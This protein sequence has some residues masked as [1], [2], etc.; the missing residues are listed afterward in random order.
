[1]S[2]TDSFEA[3]IADTLTAGAGLCHQKVVETVV[4]SGPEAIRQ[5]IEI[6]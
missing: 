6:G 4:K 2:P 5:L 3:H 1:M